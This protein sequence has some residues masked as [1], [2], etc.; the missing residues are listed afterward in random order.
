MFYYF[1]REVEPGN[2][3]VSTSTPTC[4]PSDTPR[5]LNL[6]QLCDNDP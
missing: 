4:L 6:R 3:S 1:N 5:F 2:N